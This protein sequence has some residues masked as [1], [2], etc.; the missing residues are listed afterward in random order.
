MDAVFLWIEE[1]ALSEWITQSPSLFAFPAILALH[2]I[3]MGFL[4]GANIAI[5]LRILGFA[6]DIPLS[7]MERFVPAMWTGFWLNVVSGILLLVAYPTKAFTN[8]VFYLKL[9]FIALALFH[10]RWLRD[11]VIRNPELIERLVPDRMKILAGTS[12]FLW[13]AAI[14]AGRLLA[15]TYTRLTVFS[16]Y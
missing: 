13:L 1:S 9:G 12:I 11:G 14:T 5:D 8:P 6:P 4:A 7:T 3:G 10:T 2:T 15:Y 16:D